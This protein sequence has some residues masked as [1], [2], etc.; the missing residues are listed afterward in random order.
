[1]TAGLSNAGVVDSNY[2][3][4]VPGANMARPYEMFQAYRPLVTSQNLHHA[5]PS[6]TASTGKQAF[7]FYIAE[8]RLFFNE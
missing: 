4:T 3:C 8:K 2:N 6:V 5:T 1:M 7:Y